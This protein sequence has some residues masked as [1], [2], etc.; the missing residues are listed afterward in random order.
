MANQTDPSFDSQMIELWNE[1]K[2]LL[3]QREQMGPKE[4]VMTR[5][6]TQVGNLLYR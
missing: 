3:E 2:S 5:Y 6:N 4:I 1:V